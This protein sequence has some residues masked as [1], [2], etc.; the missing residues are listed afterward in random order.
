[1]TYID[2]SEGSAE[3]MEQLGWGM[4]GE[5][6]ERIG[7]LVIEYRIVSSNLFDTL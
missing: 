4:A 2:F 5:E 1:M 3:A 7:N 6:N